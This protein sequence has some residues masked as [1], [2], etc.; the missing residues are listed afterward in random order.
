MAD[1]ATASPAWNAATIPII[2]VANLEQAS[3]QDL[4]LN[5]VSADIGTMKRG[6]SGTG[7]HHDARDRDRQGNALHGPFSFV[8][9]N[10]IGRNGDAT[11]PDS[12]A[13]C[14]WTHADE[15]GASNLRLRRKLLEL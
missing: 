6:A 2:S 3:G 8:R 13:Y 1:S 7:T 11:C 14:A 10:G 15:I 12:E 4:S 9:A 5:L